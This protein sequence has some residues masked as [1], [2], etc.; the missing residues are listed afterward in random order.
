MPF[1]SWIKTL[2]IIRLC[3]TYCLS[4]F[5]CNNVHTNAPQCY[6]ER[7]LSVF[8]PLA[9]LCDQ[10]LLFPKKFS[11][12]PLS[13]CLCVNVCCPTATGWQPNCSY[14]MYHI[15]FKHDD[16][17]IRPYRRQIFPTPNTELIFTLT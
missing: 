11:S 13:H 15:N 16:A 3:N 2:Q 10:L 4:L 12:F 1:T 8:I 7:T 6:V 9:R 14:Q 5:R 17:D